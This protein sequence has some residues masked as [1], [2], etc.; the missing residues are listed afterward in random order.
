MTN[1]Q[2]LFISEYLQDFNATK[3]AERAGYSMDTAYSQGHRLLKH[4]EIREK[5]K[6]AAD[7]ALEARK[8]TL[9]HEVI[10]KLYDAAMSGPD[11]KA[12]KDGKI[13]G[14]SRRDSLKA[15]ELLGKYMTMFTEKIEH[16]GKIELFNDM[17]DDEALARIAVLEAGR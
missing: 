16:G 15:L 9:R 10:D 7:E 12:D 17:T 14:A 6:K 5:I 8:I 3:A 2:K 4:V 1:K 11:I 13:I